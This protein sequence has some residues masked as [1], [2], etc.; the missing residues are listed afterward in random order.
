M[1]AN[2]KEESLENRTKTRHGRQ[3]DNIRVLDVNVGAEQKDQ[4]Q[5][6]VKFYKNPGH[7][8]IP[9]DDK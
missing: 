4:K 2:A 9:F 1:P 3:K 5:G 8:I 6:S 7:E